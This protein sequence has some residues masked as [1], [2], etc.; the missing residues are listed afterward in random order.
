MK[1]LSDKE[2]FFKF[3]NVIL[4]LEARELPIILTNILTF[5][6]SFFS[7]YNIIIDLGIFTSCNFGNSHLNHLAILPC[8]FATIVTS[9]HQN[10][11][12]Y[13]LKIKDI[14]KLEVQTLSWSAPQ[15]DQKSFPSSAL[16]ENIN[17]GELT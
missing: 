12:T 17:Y 15:I 9:P 10:K 6:G 1:K 4:H 11:Y 8:P 13:N 5:S 2:F 16:N 3:C 14:K 7:Q